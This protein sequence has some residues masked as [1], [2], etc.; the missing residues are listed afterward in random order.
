MLKVVAH[1]A[2]VA[3][4][5]FV[6]HDNEGV[7]ASVFLPGFDDI[8]QFV[9]RSERPVGQVAEHPPVV[10]AVFFEETFS[11][12]VVVRNNAA[13]SPD[14]GGVGQLMA[15]MPIGDGLADWIAESV[16][17]NAERRAESIVGQGHNTGL[18]R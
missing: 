1:E 7:Q 4:R 14:Q 6:L 18:G 15:A 8:V 9:D 3:D 13:G 10:L 11:K 12:N 5:M 17:T 2:G 16:V